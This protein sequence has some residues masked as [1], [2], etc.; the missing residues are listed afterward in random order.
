VRIGATLLLSLA[1]GAFAPGFKCGER[2]SARAAFGMI[3]LAI[4]TIG[5]GFGPQCS[6]ASVVRGQLGHRSKRWRVTPSVF[7]VTVATIL[8]Y[9]FAWTPASR[10]FGLSHRAQAW[11]LYRT[12][13]ARFS[14]PMFV[15]GC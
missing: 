1:W 15:S 9:G 6:C 10:S 4:L 14:L 8:F 7:A 13:P 11:R 2:A 3:L 5:P 12:G